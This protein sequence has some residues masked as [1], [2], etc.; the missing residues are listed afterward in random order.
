M[1]SAYLAGERQRQGPERE[2][3]TRTWIHL[4]AIARL[5]NYAHV[6]NAAVADIR[7]LTC[8]RCKLFDINA[9]QA[10]YT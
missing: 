9:Q 2:R 1:S 6:A 4:F 3:G 10:A 8:N 5:V 7:T